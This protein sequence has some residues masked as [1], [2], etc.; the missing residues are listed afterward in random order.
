M[1]VSVYLERVIDELERNAQL[2]KEEE[3]Q[4]MADVILR[5]ER[6]FVAGTGRTGFAARA[7][8]NRLM[9][10]GMTVYRGDSFSCSDGKKSTGDRGTCRNC[11][12]PSG[13]FDRKAGRQGHLPARGHSKERTGRY[14]QQCAGHGQFL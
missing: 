10:L 8:S 6:V 11:Y 2:V 9:Q 5:A 7:F 14:L 1:A 13:G 12:D 3:L 4:A